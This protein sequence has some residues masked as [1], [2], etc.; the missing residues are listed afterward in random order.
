MWIF[1]HAFFF[2]T[3][4]YIICVWYIIRKGVYDMAKEK[5]D[6]REKLT[7]YKLEFGMLE[8]KPCT[9]P[10]N[11]AY[12]NLLKNGGVL[13]DGVFRY[14]NADG[15]KTDEFYTT[16]ASDLTETEIQEYLTYQKLKYIKTIKNCA[17]F[18]TA[19]TIVGM[20]C[21]FLLMLTVFN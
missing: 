21:S 5:V 16:C 4:E 13:P 17:V 7:E 12:L 2:F 20:V 6:V 3:L 15:E 19:L 11:E 14:E 1:L 10:E 9:K 18:F 8:K